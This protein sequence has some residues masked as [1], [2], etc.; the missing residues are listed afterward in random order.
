VFASIR[1]AMMNI[2]A[3]ASSL[4]YINRNLLFVLLGSVLLCADVTAQQGMMDDKYRSRYAQGL[5]AFRVGGGINRYLGEFTALDDARLISMSAMY[6]IRPFL[7]AGLRVDYGMVSYNRSLLQVDPQLY[8]F[9]FGTEGSESETELSMF[10]LA[11]QVT[12]IQ[13]SIFDLYIF[14]GA[15]VAVYDAKDH[16]S[17]VARVRPKAD[18]PGTVSIPFG[19]GLDIHITESVAFSSEIQYKMFFVGDIDAYDEKLINIDFIKSGGKRPYNPEQ[20]NDHLFSL[21]AGLKVFLFRNSDYDGDLISNWQEEDLG[22]DP[23]DVDSDDDGLSDYQEVQIH[24]SNPLLRD[25]DNDGLSDYEEITVFRTNPIVRDT[26]GDGLFD[27]DEIYRYGTNPLL[28]DTDG[29]GLSDKEELDV[30]TDPSHVDTDRDGLSDAD[31]VRIY[32]TTPLKPDSDG[33]GVFDYNEVMTYGTNPL[34]IDTDGDELSDY[35][36]IAFHRTNPVRVDTDGDGLRDDYEIEVSRTN[37]LDRDTDGD[38]IWDGVDTCPL[39]PENYNGIDDSDGCPDGI[40][41]PSLPIAS[42]GDRGV[43][44]GPGTGEGGDKGQGTGPGTGEG[45]DK[46]Q[47][48]GPGT[49]EGGDKGQGTGPGTGEGGDKGHGT[50]VGTGEGGDKGHGTGVGT[51]EGG[52]KGHGTGVGT[53]EGG[54]TGR[55]TG[56]G[57]G[58]GGDSGFG[59]EVG[60]GEGGV[61]S[62]ERRTI[63]GPDP[64]PLLARYYDYDPRYVQHIVPFQI[65]DTTWSSSVQYDF[66]SFIIP[67]PL[68]EFTAEALEDNKTFMLGDIHFEF[69]R[70]ILPKE[71]LA[72]L[73]A[74][75]HVFKIYPELIVEIRGHTDNE[76]TDDYNINLSMRRA[77]AVKHFFVQQGVASRRII[78]KGFGK[79]RPLTD[80]ESEI[81]KAI[82]RR[83]EM[84]VVQLGKRAGR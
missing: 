67:K 48:T 16:G 10:H 72:E 45:G 14:L 7:S 11:L 40:G 17:D 27:F 74:K 61:W 21:S 37:A 34:K 77:L 62:R 60:V 5:L 68:P 50:G 64:R 20:V 12:P 23:Y 2:F 81:G 25:S 38:G 6:S 63:F 33:D 51:G 1:R 4:K 24:K 3:C 75:V 41:F 32:R 82:N 28:A 83:V 84:H 49:G 78:A 31:E 36:E 55:G 39:V 80:N 30:G 46:G 52:D 56:V 70:A 69:D 26:D 18:M 15:G 76:G 44:T 53:G 65:I 35:E 22:S 66:S 71:Y 47:G 8:E 42:R 19:A 57:T 59:T 43:G 79:T 58:E 9:Q 13:W 73:M 29:D 54:D